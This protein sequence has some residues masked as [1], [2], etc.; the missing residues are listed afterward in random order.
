MLFIVNYGAQCHLFL[1]AKV[2]VVHSSESSCIN[3]MVAKTLL[4]LALCL[5]TS[6][7]RL[8]EDSD[9]KALLEEILE[10]LNEKESRIS[11]LENLVQQ[12]QNRI[13]NLETE[14]AAQKQQII[15]LEKEN[16]S[17]KETQEASDKEDETNFAGT[18]YFQIAAM[19]H[20]IAVRQGTA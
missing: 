12:Q 5:H 14:V 15:A 8:F 19:K 11:K 13:V 18:H 2:R 6:L 3:K 10:K 1:S 20:T 16:D 7:A 9:T 17:V 4:L